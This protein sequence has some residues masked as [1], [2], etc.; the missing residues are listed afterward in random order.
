MAHPTT[1]GFW[2]YLHEVYSREAI[3][4]P[5]DRTLISSMHSIGIVPVVDHLNLM[6]IQRKS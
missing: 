5:E 2:E 1:E 6:S 3:I 4:R